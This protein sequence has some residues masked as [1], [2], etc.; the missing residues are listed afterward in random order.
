MIDGKNQSGKKNRSP[1]RPW[2]AC[3]VSNLIDELIADKW[4]D[5]EDRWQE[6]ANIYKGQ[7]I[8]EQRNF[9]SYRDRMYADI[10]KATWMD[11]W[12]EYSEVEA[13]ATFAPVLDFS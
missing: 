8:V 5:P 2:V 6:I 12:I 1:V 10:Y 11:R 9:N 7:F 13:K 3:S 4:I